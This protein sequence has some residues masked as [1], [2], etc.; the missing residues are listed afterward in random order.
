MSE[1]FSSTTMRGSRLTYIGIRSIL[2]NFHLHIRPKVLTTDCLD[3][4]LN[5]AKYEDVFDNVIASDDAEDQHLFTGVRRDRW[6]NFSEREFVES[7]VSAHASVIEWCR[8]K[9]VFEFGAGH[10]RI[11]LRLALR[12]PHL[13][14][15][16]VE[17][18]LNGCLA[19]ERAIKL[20]EVTNVEIQHGY[21]AESTSNVA[22][23]DLMYSNLAFEQ[24]GR[25]STVDEILRVML[26]LP[27][28]RY[29][30]FLEPL[31]DAQTRLTLAYLRAMNY[32]EL[33]TSDLEDF[34]Y[35]IIQSGQHSHHHNIRFRLSHTVV[36]KP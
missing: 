30:S 26:N 14:F 17:P 4:E 32:L 15:I 10:G 23:A 8:A 2:S 6:A 28:L 33:S 19:I 25:R 11:L 34:G 35:Q 21:L 29:V 16:G 27:N 20:F 3:V 24:I 9:R 5:K 18:T 13:T 7:C 36:S 12:F 31:Q 1:T 22:S